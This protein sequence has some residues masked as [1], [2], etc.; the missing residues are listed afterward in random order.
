MPFEFKEPAP[1]REYSI[2]LVDDKQELRV[3]LARRLE[4]VGYRVTEAVHGR[5]ALKLLDMERFD[6]VLLDLNMPDLDGMSTLT[7]IKSNARLR[8]MPVVMLTANSDNAS[9]VACLQLGAA[10]YLIKPINPLELSQRVHRCLRTRAAPLEPTVELGDIAGARVLVVDDEPLNLKLL[11][12]RLEQ[13]GYAVTCAADGPSALGALEQACFD[14]VLLDVH[15]PDVSGFE[16]LQ[17][18]RADAR[19]KGMAV[20]M[21]SADDAQETVDRSYREGADDYLVKP[22]HTPDLQMRLGVVLDL[23]RNRREAVIAS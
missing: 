23:R 10:D 17:S 20:L 13:M 21:L 4:K 5:H 11:K 18:I 9:V 19:R 3:L 22:Y 1:E 2:L 12:R 6:L 8:A 14:A 15:M 7:E 16:V